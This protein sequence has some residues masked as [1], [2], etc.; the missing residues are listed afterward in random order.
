M[1]KKI[2]TA[3]I[4][5]AASLSFVAVAQAE[6]IPATPM[7]HGPMMAPGAA[8]MAAAEPMGGEPMKAPMRKHRMMKKSMSRKMMMKKKM[9]KH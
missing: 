7:N 8:P 2:A 6:D 3:A 1:F 9:M 5:G 4:I